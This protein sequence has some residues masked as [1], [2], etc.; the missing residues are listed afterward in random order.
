MCFVVFYSTYRRCGG[1]TSNLTRDPL[2]NGRL[3]RISSTQLTTFCLQM[4][5]CFPPPKKERTPQT[6]MVTVE[7]R[8]R[9][10]FM[11]KPLNLS[12]EISLQISFAATRYFLF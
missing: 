8:S 5:L 7:C 1:A 11:V 2:L 9:V 10:N 6:G 12:C 4:N 3:L